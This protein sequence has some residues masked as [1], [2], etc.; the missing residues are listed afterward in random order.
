MYSTR[1][2][3]AAA[4]VAASLIGCGK[5]PAPLQ[6][7]T[8]PPAAPSPAPDL[9]PPVRLPAAPQAAAPAAKPQFELEGVSSEAPALS[10]SPNARLL[11]AALT[12]FS[13]AEVRTEHRQLIVTRRISPDQ[14]L[15]VV[16]NLNEM[17][18]EGQPLDFSVTY[19]NRGFAASDEPRLIRLRCL[20]EARSGIDRVNW[21]IDTR[22][23]WS[24]TAPEMPA[25]EYMVAVSA[26]SPR[27]AGFWEGVL[28]GAETNRIVQH[29]RT[30]LAPKVRDDLALRP[31]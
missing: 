18:A 9:P 5:E 27:P 2:L 28:R 8:G 13:P 14:D 17:D 24:G 10:L 6:E 25:F 19:R 7:L 11:A 15:T 21:I 12:G 16:V 30:Y 4:A 20:S 22:R 23:D 29:C 1:H 31:R 26:G 3:A